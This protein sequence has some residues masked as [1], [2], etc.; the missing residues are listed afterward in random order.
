MSN[1][2][3]SYADL[4]RVPMQALGRRER[5]GYDGQQAS[6]RQRSYTWRKREGIILDLLGTGAVG[7][8]CGCGGIGMPAAGVFAVVKQVEV[9]HTQ[10]QVIEQP[11]HHQRVPQT[12][13]LHTYIHTYIHTYSNCY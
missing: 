7:P 11:L 5:V 12:A 3:L 1:Q 6:L 10:Q 8:Q 2:G 4:H 13:H 9:F